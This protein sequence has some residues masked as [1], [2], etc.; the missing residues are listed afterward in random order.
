[1]H[2]T[3]VRRWVAGVI[4]APGPVLIAL[5]TLTGRWGVENRDWEGWVIRGNWLWA[6]TGERFHPG[7]LLGLRYRIQLQKY[8]EQQIAL[9]RE[10]IAR[11]ADGAA[12]DAVEGEIAPPS[13]DYTVKRPRR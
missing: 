9:L 4:V 5:R 7:D 8:H 13:V 11:L 1:V 10:K 2:I 3:T 12:N 6:P